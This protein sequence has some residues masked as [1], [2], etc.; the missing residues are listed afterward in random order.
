MTLFARGKWSRFILPLYLVLAMIGTLVFA[1]PDALCFAELDETENLLY[2]KD[3]FAPTNITDWLAP[4]T[5]RIGRAKGHGPLLIRSGV[6]RVSLSLG[7]PGFQAALIQSLLKT[8]VKVQYPPGKNAVQP[9]LR[10]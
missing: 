1:A 7:T 10:I 6:H 2:S 8:T 5:A 9:K 3:F 4:G